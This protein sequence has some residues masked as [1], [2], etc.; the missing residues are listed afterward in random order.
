MNRYNY[1]VEIFPNLFCVTFLN[2]ETKES[3][4]FS[5]HKSRND[6]LGLEQFLNQ[7][8]VLIG[9]NNLNY[10][11]PMIQ[12]LLQNKSNKNIIEDL[13]EFSTKL[14][15]SE[16][17]QFNQAWK[18]Y[19]YPENIKYSQI[20]LMKIIEIS[21]VAPSL[22]Q[23]AIT[24]QWWRIQDL[25]L[26]YN[27]IVQTEEEEKLIYEYN[28]NDVYITDK[29]YEELLPKIELREGLSSLY[30]VNLMSA[31]D[32]K[33][34][35][36]I[37]EK[38]YVDELGADM[39]VIRNLRTKREQFFLSECIAP[40][41]K[42]ETNFFNR[43]KEEIAETLVRKSNNYKYSKTIEF[44]GVTYELGVGGIHSVDFPAKFISDE[45]W[46]ILDEDVS[47]FY[48]S[49][50][51]NNKIIPEHLGL[52]FIR[53]LER[54]TKERLAAK[55]INKVKAEA[56]KITINAIFGKLG[57]DTFWLEDPKA[58]R[59]VTVSGQLYLLML[60]E[61]LVLNNIQVIS[62]NTDGVVSRIHKS[63]ETLFKEICNWWQKE[64]NLNLERTDYLM[65]FRQ[66]VNNYVTK[67]TDGKTKEKGRYLQE[68]NV[69][70][71]YKHPIIPIAMYQFIVNN[72]PVEETI[73]NHKNILDFCISQ[74]SG[75]E[76]KIEYHLDNGDI[77][78][79]QKNN[80]FFVSNSGGALYKRR[81]NN[82][83][84]G[85]VVGE[86]VII[87][88]DYDS[89]KDIKEYDIKYEYYIN[90][91]KKYTDEV[92]L[93]E[94][95][96]T[97]FI[98]EEKNYRPPTDNKKRSDFFFQFQKVKN[99]PEKFVD[100]LM[101]LIENFPENNN[102]FCDFLQYSIDNDKFSNKFLQ[103]IKLNY[104]QRFGNQKKLITFYNEFVSGENKYSKTLSNKSKEKRILILRDYW[105]WMPEYTFSILEQI[106]NEASVN[107]IPF[108]KYNVNKFYVYISKIDTKS[109]SRA[110]LKTY[111][112]QTGEERELEIF[113]SDLKYK[114]ENDK[115][116]QTLKEGDIILCKNISKKFYKTMKE[117]GSG[118]IN[119][120]KS[121]LFLDS[122]YV[123]TEKDEFYPPE[124]N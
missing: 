31:S 43:I 6:I 27:Y 71:G 115:D 3:K 26:P 74:K 97:P 66:D 34:A 10:D 32:S 112:L 21:G 11:G 95:E 121:Y 68:R 37:L 79:L 90:E 41:I 94:K 55:K 92:I 98:D 69:K 20:D 54:I 103:I 24:L 58:L 83:L 45:N 40:N 33:M 86:K 106:N 30:G 117:D 62:A 70:K 102:S 51:I 123:M 87:L 84:I 91:A 1:D 82:T 35:D 49:M 78:K 76:F 18:K 53:V 72:I 7:E 81:E 75:N 22:K 108:S 15:N 89:K 50:M 42:F 93:C 80:R 73:S 124:N 29:L 38:F 118:W 60:I 46:L 64:T 119:T 52:D 23:I 56:L 13:F 100:N 8:I 122:Y 65:Y 5:I 14:I 67:K 36:K 59:S 28:L 85:I 19:Q 109:G 96:L 88:N 77:Q 101:W 44:G 61:K 116:I 48:P 107:T 110:K 99:L 57:S 25:P 12:Y 111:K 105:L 47:S 4:L 120:T 17:G 2:L 114:R 63:Q 16:R 113:K 39:K 9:Y 104:F